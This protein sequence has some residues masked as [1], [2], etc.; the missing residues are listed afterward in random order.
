MP[1]HVR[2]C[3][4]Q[5][6]PSTSEQQVKADAARHA[7]EIPGSAIEDIAAVP[8]HNNFVYAKFSLELTQMGS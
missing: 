6:S 3:L 7:V 8:H 1:F 5:A 2:D 4:C